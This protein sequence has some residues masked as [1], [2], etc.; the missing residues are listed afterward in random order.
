[1]SYQ[2]KRKNKN[3]NSYSSKSRIEKKESF[4]SYNRAKPDSKKSIKTKKKNT[5]RK[6]NKPVVKKVEAKTIINTTVDETLWISTPI[7]MTRFLKKVSENDALTIAKLVVKNPGLFITNLNK[8]IK[9][10]QIFNIQLVKDYIRKHWSYHKYKKNNK[11]IRIVKLTNGYYRLNLNITEL[12]RL[13]QVYKLSRNEM[14]RSMVLKVSS[15]NDATFTLTKTVFGYGVALN[16]S[17]N[18]ILF[19]NDKKLIDLVSNS[20]DPAKYIEKDMDYVVLSSA[21]EKDIDYGKFKVK[22]LPIKYRRD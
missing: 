17:N 8:D 16:P 13:H 1:M 15:L 20:N 4:K 5:T 21:I 2:T 14:T 12:F 9:V 10:E 6:L 19:W 22:E 18:Y 7:K 3:T 11:L